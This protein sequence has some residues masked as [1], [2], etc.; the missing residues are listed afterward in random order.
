MTP[1]VRLTV[2]L[3]TIVLGACSDPLPEVSTGLSSAESSTGGLP[4]P[5]TT[6]TTPGED[7]LGTM[8]GTGMETTMG[9]A[10]SMTDPTGSDETT[11]G[12]S[13]MSSSDG[14]SGDPPPPGCVSDDQCANSETCDGGGNCVSACMPAW[15]M[16][17]YGACVN[18]YGGTDI[19]GLCG[20]TGICLVDQYPINGSTCSRQG[21]VDACDCPPPP[22]SGNAT[23]TCA[24]I[25]GGGD[26]GITDCYLS[27]AAGETCPD[28]LQCYNNS[29]CMA[30]LDVNPVPIYGN[31]G[32]IPA[33]CAAPGFC[34]TDGGTAVCQQSCGDASDCPAA[35]PTGNA[36]VTCGFANMAVSG[37]ECHLDCSGGQT[38][39]VGMFCYGGFMCAF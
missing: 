15:G 6:A 34:F 29:V 10:D 39:P 28:G 12:A 37:P 32:D 17:N 21:C 25:T 24:N 36:P 1:W 5:T 16:G 11:A 27:C 38:C 33:A 31:C 8:G 7:S 30:A 9:A 2:P 14:S 18:E 20:G 22:D 23:V 26:G 19:N 13:S 4:P 35:P 3:A